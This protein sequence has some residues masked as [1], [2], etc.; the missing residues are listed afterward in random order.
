LN[1]LQYYTFISVK[2]DQT[3]TLANNKN[4]A[5]SSSSITFPLARL[6]YTLFFSE[7][8]RQK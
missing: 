3:K 2:Y 4:A 8:L 5:T 6:F 7:R 1:G